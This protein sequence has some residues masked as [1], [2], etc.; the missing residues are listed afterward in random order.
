MDLCLLG[1]KKIHRMKLNKIFIVL[2]LITSHCVLGQ[3][4]ID[5]MHYRHRI[6][7]SADYMLD[8]QHVHSGVLPTVSQTF[9]LHFPKEKGQ[10]FEYKQAKKSGDEINLGLRFYPLADIGLGTEIQKNKTDYFKYSAGL[11]AGFDFASHK[12]FITGKLM[13]MMNEV[14]Y[15]SDSIRQHYAM[16]LGTTRSIF[17]DLFQRNELLMAYRPNKFFTFLGGYGKNFFGEGYRSLLLSD[18]ASNYPFLK[19]ETSF[20]SIKYVN[21][22]TVWNDNSI[23]PSNKNLDRTKFSSIHY[24]SWNVTREFNL[25]VFESVVWQAKDTITN[26]GFDINYLNPVVFYRP[27]EYGMGSADNV[28]LGLNMSYKIN[29]NHC[30][31]SQV[32]IDEFLLSKIK[33]D[34]KWWGN[35]WGVQFGYKSNKFL[36]DDLY[37][38]SEFNVVRPFTYSHKYSTQNYGHLNASV[39][40]PI[41]ANFYEVLN[42]LSYA[43]NNHRF[44]NKITFAAFGVDTDSINNGQN[45]FNS[46]SDRKDDFGHL[47]MQGLRTNVLN[48]QLIYEFPIWEKINLYLNVTYN[49][50]MQY[51]SSQITHN[52][53]IMVGVKSRFWNVYNDI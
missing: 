37:F 41:G 18:N 26:R 36:I 34:S 53:F 27:V 31:Y 6:Q 50:R 5:N 3:I 10:I 38:Q 11:G 44:T 12:I 43:K 30:I 33:D 1:I 8:Q 39:T 19:I 52:H 48:E 20:S 49:Y 23:N 40:H 22:Y 9:Q 15:A 25:S 42:I 13:P 32:I 21:L 47:I 51:N 2:I 46:Y 4:T 14:G 16:D 35:K 29:K 45:I 7:N 24:L 28:L 17:G